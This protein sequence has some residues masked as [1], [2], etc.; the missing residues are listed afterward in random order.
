MKT[1]KSS[2]E[3]NT[4]NNEQP[5]NQH[6]DYNSEYHNHNRDPFFTDRDLIR[7]AAFVFVCGTLVLAI[8]AILFLVTR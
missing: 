2:P 4:P 7:P 8:V 6:C 3:K 5:H 1:P